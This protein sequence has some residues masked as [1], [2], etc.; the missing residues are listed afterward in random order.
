MNPHTLERC[1]FFFFLILSHAGRRAESRSPALVPEHCLVSFP[2][3]RRWAPERLDYPSGGWGRGCWPI[4]AGRC[5]NVRLPRGTVELTPGGVCA[6]CLYR[7]RHVLV[8]FPVALISRAPDSRGSQSLHAVLTLP[9]QTPPEA[10][11]PNPPRS[12]HQAFPSASSLP[13]PPIRVDGLHVAL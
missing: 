2:R 8:H 13:R 5:F 9:A 10:R 12:F 3:S 4:P 7:E 1:L 11:A 6:I